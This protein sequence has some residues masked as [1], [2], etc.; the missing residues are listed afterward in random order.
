M[1]NRHMKKCSTSL[2]IREIK[3]KTILRYHLRAVRMGKIDKARKQQMLE[4]MWR[5]GNPLILL[6]G[7]Q[8][9]KATL[10]NSVEVPQNL[11]IELP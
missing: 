11:K 10:E 8:V 2:A 9:G 1:A 6:V 3:I 7:M 4:R 5:E